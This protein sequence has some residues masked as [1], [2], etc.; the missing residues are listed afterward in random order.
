[1]LP[2]CQVLE[3][4]KGYKIPFVSMPPLQKACL[5]DPHIYWSS[6]D[7]MGLKISELLALGAISEV[8]LG[9]ECFLSPIFLV[10]KPDGSSRFILNLKRLNKFVYTEH[11]KLDDIRVALRLLEQNMYAGLIDFK[12][13][14][15]LVKIHE[16]YTKYLTFGYHGKFFRMNCLPMGLASAPYVFH[17]LLRPVMA[18]LRDKNIISVNYL[19]DCCF[20]AK[21]YDECVSAM[22]HG[23]DIF[24]TLGFVI[25]EHKSN[26]MPS[27]NFNFLGFCFD[28]HSMSIGLPIEKQLKVRQSVQYL[29]D[30]EKFTIRCLARVIGILISMKFAIPFGLLY[31]RSL[32]RDRYVA[33]SKSGDNFNAMCTITT[34]SR[35]DLV[36]WL[37]SMDH[38]STHIRSD[39]HDEVIF[40]DA[41]D[42]GWGSFWDPHRACG[43]WSETDRKNHIN[44]KEL[45]AIYLA[46]QTFASQWTEKSV[47]LRVDNV[48]AIALINK[49][50]SV[51]FP[52]LHDVAKLIW[53]FCEVRDL[54]LVASYINTTEN[55]VA[56]FESRRTVSDTEWGLSRSYFDQLTGVLGEPQ[57]DLFASYDL[58]NCD[59]F[60][61][62]THNPLQRE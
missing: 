52:H 28:S 14:Y 19:D 50:G 46:L 58:H 11:F 35:E 37:G 53:Q 7:D 31:T 6:S 13:A 41:S 16:D 39:S 22:N 29:L 12:D 57:V 59:R 24:Q 56:D 40:T 4:V 33:L 44:W 47:L 48:T 18:K 15:Y 36:W 45:M 5:G 1:M 9:S 43:W 2:P 21:S 34:Q 32:E 61:L 10:P 42:S 8:P 51:Q 62:G 17:K 55:L 20:L 23:R 30:R 60:F 54:W 3:W 49:Q 26:F 38:P 27:Q 25:N